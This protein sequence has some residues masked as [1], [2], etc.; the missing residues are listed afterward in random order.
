MLIVFPDVMLSALFGRTF[1][2]NAP[3]L[4]IFAVA[5]FFVALINTMSNFFLAIEKTRFILVLLTGCFV[6]I[7]LIM[8]FHQQLFMIPCIVTFVSVVMCAVFLFQIV[9]PHVEK[10]AA[11]IL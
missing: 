10:Y 2:G 8:V 3:L 5:M 7:G 11:K 4:R 1:S 9:R 6:E